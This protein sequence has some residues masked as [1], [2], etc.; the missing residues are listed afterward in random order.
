MD[1]AELDLA[2][3]Q[4]ARNARR[5]RARIGKVEPPRDALLEDVEM[6]RQ[7]HAGL[8]HVQVAD[9]SGVEVRKRRGEDVGLLLVVALQAHPVA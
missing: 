5:L 6:G 3:E 1:R 2:A 9:L 4:H 8:H 7:D